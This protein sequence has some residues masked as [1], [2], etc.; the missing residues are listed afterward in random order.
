MPPSASSPLLE[1]PLPNIRRPT[2]A[3][4]RVDTDQRR[5]SVVVV[6]F[7]AKY[8]APCQETLPATQALHAERG[9]VLV[10]GVSEDED[11]D[12][13]LEQVARY[14]LTFPVVLDR[15]NVI[16]GRFRVRELPAAVVADRNGRIVWVGG[17]EQG[18]HDLRRAVEAVPP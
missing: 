9:D 8:C 3:G 6:K 10:I 12:S 11:E 15:G 4:Q 5:G 2:L 17:P 14:G 13:A 16:A 7:F 18:E 1:R